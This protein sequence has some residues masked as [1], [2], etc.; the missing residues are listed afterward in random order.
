MHDSASSVH[1]PHSHDW[2]K[3]SDVAQWIRCSRG[4]VYRAIKNGHLRAAAVNQRGDV[5]IHRDWV[6]QWLD[7][8]VVLFKP[9]TQS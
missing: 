7:E 5:R 8:Q 4:S 1:G 2:L 3:V 9:G 6:R